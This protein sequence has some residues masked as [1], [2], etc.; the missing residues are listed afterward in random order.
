MYDREGVLSREY[1]KKNMHVGRMH[2]YILLCRDWWGVL[3]LART[4][5]VADTGLHGESQWYNVVP[6]LTQCSMHALHG[7]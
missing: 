3:V 7:R 6:Y 2:L 5:L 4:A 1:V